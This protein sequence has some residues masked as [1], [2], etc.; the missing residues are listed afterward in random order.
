MVLW[1][2]FVNCFWLAVL[3]LITTETYFIKESIASCVMC[4]TH[5]P[6]KS[7]TCLGLFR[8]KSDTVQPPPSHPPPSQL[9]LDSGALPRGKD[10]IHR[11]W[12]TWSCYGG[13]WWV[14][15]CADQQALLDFAVIHIWQE[16]DGGLHF[17]VAKIPAFE[18]F[19]S[20]ATIEYLDTKKQ[21]RIYFGL[22]FQR[23]H[24]GNEDTT[25][26]AGWSLS[27]HTQEE[28]EKRV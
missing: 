28:R 8:R 26:H 24:H 12:L 9:I 25:T 18:S 20:V 27:I 19:F 4:L 11:N 5:S 22:P 13:E 2:T 17:S 7:G 3:L 16:D 21:G 23:V 14:P 6:L 10:K 1:Y 15:T